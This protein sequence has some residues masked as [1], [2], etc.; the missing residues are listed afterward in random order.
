ML[1]VPLVVRLQ[2]AM[3]RYRKTVTEKMDDRNTGNCNMCSLY[4]I[5][6]GLLTYYNKAYMCDITEENL[7]NQIHT[8]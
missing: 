1:L 6:I 4:I 2:R 7:C 5:M 3:N 8:K